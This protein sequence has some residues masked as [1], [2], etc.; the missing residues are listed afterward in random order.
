MNYLLDQ[1]KQQNKCV[2]TELLSVVE[3]ATAVVCHKADIVLS[4]THF[5]ECSNYVLTPLPFPVKMR[6]SQGYLFVFLLASL[7]ASCTSNCPTS[8]SYD[9]CVQALQYT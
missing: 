1:F 3:F 4:K 9:N 6:I 5:I 8:E 7:S 2:L